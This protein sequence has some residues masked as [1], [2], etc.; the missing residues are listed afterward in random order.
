MSF[1]HRSTVKDIQILAESEFA[2]I[3][4]ISLPACLFVAYLRGLVA[5][6]ASMAPYRRG[7]ADPRAAGFT[8]EVSGEDLEKP[9][10]VKKSEHMDF[11][12]RKLG[13]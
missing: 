5:M 10:M 13:K 11:L 2:A 3:A 8:E 7:T 9:N 12:K 1:Y 6:A 4:K